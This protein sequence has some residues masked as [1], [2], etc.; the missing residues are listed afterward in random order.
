MYVRARRRCALRVYLGVCVCFMCVPCLLV[1]SRA[2]CCLLYQ[3]GEARQAPCVFDWVFLARWAREGACLRALQLQCWVGGGPQAP[4]SECVGDASR[5]SLACVIVL[6]LAACPAVG[7][8]GFPTHPHSNHVWR[9]VWVYTSLQLL[10][11][12]LAPKRYLFKQ[13]PAWFQDL[14]S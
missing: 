10:C 13:I 7:A 14:C 2:S 8:T 4:N 6:P 5:H 12:L 1:G 11:T 3:H 9:D